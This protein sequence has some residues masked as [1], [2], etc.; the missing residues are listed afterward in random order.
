[1]PYLPEMRT[2]RPRIRGTQTAAVSRPCGSDIFTDMYGHIKVE[3][4]PG[5][6]CK[7]GDKSFYWVRVAQSWASRTFGSWFVPH[8]EQE[9][10]VTFLDGDP[11]WPLV[12]G[13]VYNAEQ[14]VPFANRQ[15]HPK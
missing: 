2:P 9:I 5:R 8:I 3:F 15:R 7:T 10:V 12:V 11:D 13:L 6:Q 1:M 14:M 4:H